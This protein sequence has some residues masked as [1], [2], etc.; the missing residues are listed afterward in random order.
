MRLDFL[1]A[2]V[3]LIDTSAG[4]DPHIT[5]IILIETTYIFVRVKQLCQL[6]VGGSHHVGIVVIATQPQV[7]LSVAVSCLN[8][9]A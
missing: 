6:A 5:I 2:H 7:S 1:I 8:R 3:G 9:A 4:A